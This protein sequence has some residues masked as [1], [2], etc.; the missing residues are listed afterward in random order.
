[1][2]I[3]IKINT[4][5]DL[6]YIFI[7]ETHTHTHNITTQALTRLQNLTVKVWDLNTDIVI[8]T[9]SDQTN[10][11]QLY[12]DKFD[13]KLSEFLHDTKKRYLLQTGIT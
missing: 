1:M 5:I 13:I 6:K 12:R 8:Q 10:A 4:W 2:N 11:Q 9:M 3:T 7:N